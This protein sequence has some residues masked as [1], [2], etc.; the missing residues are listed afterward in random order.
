MPV[1]AAA[2]FPER[3][4]FFFQGEANECAIV[5]HRLVKQLTAMRHVVTLA[6]II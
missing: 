2:I 5:N 3:R 6:A 1:L 4:G